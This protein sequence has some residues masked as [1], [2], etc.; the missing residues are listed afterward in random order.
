MCDALT[1]P[2]LRGI[3]KTN[4]PTVLYPDCTIVS[5]CTC[6][7]PITVSRDH[8]FIWRHLR[9]R[10]L[11]TSCS[12][13]RECCLRALCFTCSKLCS[14]VLAADMHFRFLFFLLINV[15]HPFHVKLNITGGRQSFTGFPSMLSTGL[16]PSVLCAFVTAVALYSSADSLMSA[17]HLQM[18]PAS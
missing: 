2:E 1:H 7:E 13:L 8:Y 6:P 10:S 16:S 18:A 5:C 9:A 11:H 15:L 12:L 17:H 4:L 3:P 14:T